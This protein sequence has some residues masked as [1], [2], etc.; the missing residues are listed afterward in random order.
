LQNI[1]RDVVSK[2]HG[3]RKIPPLSAETRQRCWQQL[4]DDVLRLEK[5]LQRD[6]SQWQP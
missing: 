1:L 4:E 2:R 6:L 5:L 3:G